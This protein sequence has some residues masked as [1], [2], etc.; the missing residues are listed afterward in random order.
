M[1]KRISLNLLL[2]VALLTPAFEASAQTPATEP[3]RPEPE[4]RVGVRTSNRVSLTLRE[5]VM[6]ALENNRDIEIERLNARMNEFDLR[7]A[8]GFYDPALTAGVFYDHKVTPV[9]SLLAGGADG[10]LKTTDFAGTSGITQRLPWQGGRIQAML[11]QSRATSQNLF[12]S[13]NPQFTTSLSVEFLQPLFR[14]RRIDE[15][16]R[17][18]KI[19]KKRLD[20]SDSQFRQR[21]VEI[22]AQVE[23]AYWDLV[24]ALRDE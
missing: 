13:L 11:D 4:R 9:A 15:P 10:R 16:R 18:I 3:T 23:R 14:D 19:A 5:A 21:A 2:I 22:V 7:A 17:Q 24:F 1:K 12:N 6:M 20:L 8:R